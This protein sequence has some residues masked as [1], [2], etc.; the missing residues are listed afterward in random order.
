MKIKSD[1]GAA[2]FTPLMVAAPHG[3]KLL[4]TGAVTNNIDPIICQV[5]HH[6]HYA[7]WRHS[8]MNDMH[9]IWV[10]SW[11][12]SNERLAQNVLGKKWLNHMSIIKLNPS[13]FQGRNHLSHKAVCSHGEPA[14]DQLI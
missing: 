8:Q 4:V 5:Q 13:I 9:P 1:R 14:I 3:L 10:D 2:S 11:V 6:G 7:V 12:N